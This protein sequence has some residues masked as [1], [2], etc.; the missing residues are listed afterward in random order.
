MVQR[1][2][3]E[4]SVV[5]WRKEEREVRPQEERYRRSDRLQ[6]PLAMV[7]ITR[8]DIMTAFWKGTW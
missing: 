3:A 7:E 6:A 1:R 2:V 8:L 4:R 5:Q